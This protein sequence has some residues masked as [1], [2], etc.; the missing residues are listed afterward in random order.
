MSNIKDIAQSIVKDISE[1]ERLMANENID[2]N[3]REWLNL[4]ASDYMGE[5]R[6]LIA[7]METKKKEL[8]KET[9]SSII[10][11]FIEKE[12]RDVV[13]IKISH[14]INFDDIKGVI[15]KKLND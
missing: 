6:M 5:L 7:Q 3:D 2:K 11:E 1:L 4:R 8:N 15:V 9:K 13:D 14:D 12:G 10:K